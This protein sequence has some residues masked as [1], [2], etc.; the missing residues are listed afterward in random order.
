MRDGSAGL[1]P[2]LSPFV[3]VQSGMQLTLEPFLASAPGTS[4]RLRP[5]RRPPWH[6]AASLPLDNSGL[7]V[8][9]WLRR[10]F[11]CTSY[12]VVAAASASNDGHV[13]VRGSSA[14]A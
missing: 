5:R 4:A 12:D 2:T 10:G 3:H 8:L 14:P 11:Q 9:P 6:D 7:S 1:A 13:P